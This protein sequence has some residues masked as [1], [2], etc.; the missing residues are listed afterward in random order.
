MGMGRFVTLG[1]VVAL[2]SGCM[3][4][5]TPSEPARWTG[6]YT[7]GHEVSSFQPC[8][9]DAGYWATLPAAEAERLSKLSLEKARRVGKPYQPIHVDLT[10]A[11]RSNKGEQGFAADYDAILEVSAVH[12]VSRSI[13]AS[14]GQPG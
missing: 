11:L 9:S 12:H 5:D 2:L 7:Y 10:G 3:A 6:L 14:C 8:N 13:P 4:P 1:C